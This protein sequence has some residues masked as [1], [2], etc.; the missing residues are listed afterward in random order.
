[1]NEDNDETEDNVGDGGDEELQYAEFKE[2]VRIVWDTVKNDDSKE[3]DLLDEIFSISLEWF[4]TLAKELSRRAGNF[5][6]KE[7]RLFLSG[8]LKEEDINSIGWKEKA[9]MKVEDFV[10]EM[11]YYRLDLNEEKNDLLKTLEQD[12]L[13]VI[14]KTKKLNQK[15]FSNQEP[16]VRYFPI[17]QF[18][19]GNQKMT[20]MCIRYNSEVANEEGMNVLLTSVGAAVGIFGGKIFGEIPEELL[21]KKFGGVKCGIGT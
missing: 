6:R 9:K 10:E 5:I 8:M 16:D 1:M 2:C 20:E 3:E 17:N 14:K 4:E 15:S 11:G 13:N 19:D 7:D 21:I 12:M 18:I